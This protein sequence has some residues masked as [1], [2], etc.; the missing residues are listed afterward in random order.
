MINQRDSKFK[1]RRKLAIIVP[2][3]KLAG[4]HFNLK[5]WLLE[6]SETE[7]EVFLVHDVQDTATSLVL[8]EILVQISNPRVKCF[9]GEF[10]APGIARNFAISHI[11]SEWFWF[12][13]ADDLPQVQ[14]VLSELSMVEPKYDIVL[15]EFEVVIQFSN[16]PKL[17]SHTNSDLRCVA[18][19]PG[20]W[21]MI[22]RSEVFQ[23]YRF[24]NFRMAEDQI[25]LM[26]INFFERNLKFSRLVFYTYFRH[27]FGQLTSN[28]VALSELKST[29]PVVVSR[30]EVSEGF[31]NQYIEIMLARQISTQFKYADWSERLKLLGVDFTLMKNC[32]LGMRFRVCR[33]LLS[34][35][36]KKLV[37]V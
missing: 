23:E 3:T 11:N 36:M 5:S 8:R 14:S 30:L 10:G 16:T 17:T 33:E 26:D 20:I 29:I 15:G 18:R 12:V 22:F 19:D 35:F 24:R 27:E 32:G 7:I 9:E 21:R 2:I 4:N 34:I 37:N 31:Q 25:F 6:L 13:D 1:S 28:S